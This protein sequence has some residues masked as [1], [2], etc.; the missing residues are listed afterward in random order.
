MWLDVFG[1][2]VT[3]NHL[4]AISLFVVGTVVLVFSRPRDRDRAVSAAK[5]A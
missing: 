2:Q 1:A 4:A 3:F 5:S